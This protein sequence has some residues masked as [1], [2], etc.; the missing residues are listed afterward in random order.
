MLLVIT[1]LSL[2][3]CS[4]GPPRQVASGQD[5][6]ELRGTWQLNYI[7]GPRITFDGLYPDQKPALTFD[8]AKKKITGSTSCN[9][10]TGAFTADGKKIKFA[11]DLIMTK[12]ACT[13]DGETI[14]LQ[15]LKKINGY[16]VTAGRV[17]TLL[18]DNVAMMRF[19][20]EAVSQ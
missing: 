15:S 20:K 17:L 5:V 6:S 4:C 1:G 14:F 18:M 8:I 11:D 7:S 3:V 9:S 16:D 2:I 10:F 12:M 19:T 13:G